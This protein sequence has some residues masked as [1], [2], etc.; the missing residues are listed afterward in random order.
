MYL[1]VQPPAPAQLPAAS[2]LSV[3]SALAAAREAQ[4]WYLVQLRYHLLRSLAWPYLPSG[5]GGLSLRLMERLMLRPR[6][7]IDR[8]SCAL[9]L[10]CLLPCTRLS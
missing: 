9:K 7:F 2:K 1:H 8:D 10:R 5:T 6:F 3:A 4:A